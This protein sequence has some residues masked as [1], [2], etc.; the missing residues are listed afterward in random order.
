MDDGIDWKRKS[1]NPLQRPAQ[2][3][4]A[5]VDVSAGNHQ[6]PALIACAQDSWP[7]D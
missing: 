6:L 7:E 5:S 2:S 3:F 1:G 4:P